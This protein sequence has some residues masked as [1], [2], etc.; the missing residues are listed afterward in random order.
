[1]YSLLSP[2][3]SVDNEVVGRIS[4]GLLVLIGIGVGALT[5]GLPPTLP[6]IVFVASDDTPAD[7]ETIAKKI[8][9]V[10]VFDDENGTMWKHGVKDIDG[11]VLCVSQFTLMAKTTKGSKPDFHGAMVG[12]LSEDLSA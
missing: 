1:M 7:M 9:T 8:L 2:Y 5:P 12:V 11:E 10:R 3:T 4:K 6:L